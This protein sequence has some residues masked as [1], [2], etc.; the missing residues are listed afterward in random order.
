VT[1]QPG[2]VSNPN[3]RPKGSKNKLAQDFQKAYEAADQ[4]YPHPYLMMAEWANDPNKPIEIRAAMLKECASYRCMKPKQTLAIEKNIPVFE[5]E[6]Q[7][8]QFLSEFLS[9][10]SPD[11]EPVELAQMIRAWIISKREGKELELKAIKDDPDRTQ[12]IEIVGGLPRPPGT[13]VIMPHENGLNGQI[14]DGL[15]PPAKDGEP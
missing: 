4:K 5:N 2:N 9:E 6:D 14:I 1:F 3:G 15:P 12:R 8:E 10:I 13:N 7:A 11:L